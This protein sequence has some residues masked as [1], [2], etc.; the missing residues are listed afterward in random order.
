MT[1]MYKILISTSSF[2]LDNISER[3]ALESAGFEFFLNP[4]GRRLSENEISTLLEDNVVGLIAGVEPLTTTVLH[5]AKQ[6][7]V[8][9]RCGIGMDSVDVSAAQELGIRLS[10]TPDAPTLP[11][12]ELTLAHMLNLL[13][14]VS[15]ADRGVRNTEWKALMGSLLSEKTVGIIGFGRIGRKVAQL[16]QAFGAKV[17]AYDVVPILS[18]GNVTEVDLK[19]LLCESDLI[20]LHLPYCESTHH[21]ISANQIELMKSSA[22]LFNI[23]RGGLVDEA[24][25]YDALVA[26]RLAGAGLDA[27]ENEPYTGPLKELENVLITAHM[28]SYAREARI[29]ME[30]EAARN[31]VADLRKLGL[32]N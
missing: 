29:K 12:A 1:D 5:S 9:A 24:V 30:Q 3:C 28:G 11:V 22:F 23:S 27:F 25:L 2:D 32:F 20:S 15:R 21:F 19:T 31:L 16:V 8:I 14:S 7:K 17:F 10:N 18:I 4:Y 6:L 13:R 26:Q